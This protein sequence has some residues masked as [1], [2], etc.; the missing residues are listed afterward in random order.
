MF[1]E[2]HLFKHGPLFVGGG[3]GWWVVGGGWWVVDGVGLLYADS[4]VHV[5]TGVC[6]QMI[7]CSQLSCSLLQ[8]SCMS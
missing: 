2:I 1:M 3:W 5:C 6:A 8:G 4:T 7:T